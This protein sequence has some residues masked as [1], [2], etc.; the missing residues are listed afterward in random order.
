MRPF[1]FPKFGICRQGMIVM[2]VYTSHNCSKMKNIAPKTRLNKH[3]QNK[4]K[5]PLTYY[6]MTA[7]KRNASRNPKLY[8]FSAEP[9]IRAHCKWLSQ[10]QTRWGG[11]CF[12]GT[13]GLVIKVRLVTCYV[14]NGSMVEKSN[15]CI[16]ASARRPKKI[17]WRCR[18]LSVWRYVISRITRTVHKELK[19]YFIRNTYRLNS[20][21]Q[22]TIEK[23]P[24]RL[25]NASSIRK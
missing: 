8:T 15:L 18:P 16:F 23:Y 21:K 25:G 14:R 11:G 3:M 4:T 12:I 13:T 20:E 6:T 17:S 10:I 9:F 22:I 19:D 1:C 7:A 5:C 24:S 2:R